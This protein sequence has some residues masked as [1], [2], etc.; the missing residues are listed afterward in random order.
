MR[1]DRIFV[2]NPESVEVK[3]AEV[4]FNKPIYK[5][6]EGEAP[7]MNIF[8]GATSFVADMLFAKNVFRVKEQF[9]FPS[10]HFGLLCTM[11][12]I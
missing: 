8:K 9:L 5:E 1:L 2:T 6:G 7:M 4:I 10:D 11:K 3:Q 12:L